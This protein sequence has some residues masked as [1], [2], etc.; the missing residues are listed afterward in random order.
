VIMKNIFS[1]EAKFMLDSGNAI[2]VDVREQDE[3]DAEHIYSAN[4]V[5]LSN[6]V[7]GI[8]NIEPGN[9]KIIFHC[10]AGVRSAKACEVTKN[11][12]GDDN[13]YNMIDGIE[14]WKAA[15][16]PIIRK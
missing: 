6:F 5:P 2:L 10:K 1:P 13:I 14:G 12:F 16:F 11:I 9:K 4:L 8:S 3:F 15:G 7:N